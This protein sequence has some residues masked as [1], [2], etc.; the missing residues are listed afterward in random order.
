[1]LSALKSQLNRIV[2]ELHPVRLLWHKLQ[3]I[4]AA[5]W[6]RFPAYSMKIVG[7]TGTNGKTSTAYFTHHLLSSAGYKT[8]LFTT[9]EFKIGH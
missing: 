2:P 1:M 3:A 9:A 6:Y 8:G 7:I 5:N 4:L